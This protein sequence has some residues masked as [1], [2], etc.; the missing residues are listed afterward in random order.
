MNK[1]Y[2][3]CEFCG[4]DLRSPADLTNGICEFCLA[5]TQPPL[6]KGP[7][8]PEEEYTVSELSGELSWEC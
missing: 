4:K 8:W 6:P 2:S 7:V 1:G 3:W 5:N